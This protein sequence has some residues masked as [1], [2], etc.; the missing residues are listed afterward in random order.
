MECRQTVHLICKSNI[1]RYEKYR[2][3]GHDSIVGVLGIYDSA[4]DP[5]DYRSR[6]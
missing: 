4:A 1:K 6:C 5:N 3:D 2:V